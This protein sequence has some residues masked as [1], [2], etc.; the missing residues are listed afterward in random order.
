MSLGARPGGVVLLLPSR[1]YE[2]A[3]RSIVEAYAAGVPVIAAN[4]G[5]LP[6]FVNDGTDQANTRR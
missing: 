1:W 2:G 5:A 4:V 3:P 6:E